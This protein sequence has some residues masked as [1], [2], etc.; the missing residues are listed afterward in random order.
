[1][2]AIVN[3][4]PAGPCLDSYWRIQTP[5]L[6]LRFSFSVLHSTPRRCICICMHSCLLSLH[7]D[8]VYCTIPATIS[9]SSSTTG[10]SFAAASLWCGRRRVGRQASFSSF[11]RQSTY[12]STDRRAA[13]MLLLLKRGPSYDDPTA[14]SF[15]L[16]HLHR[17]VFSVIN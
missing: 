16:H 11:H 14:F 1:M 2:F 3:K 13:K 7:D 9:P 12:L 5:F 17:V 4:S 8:G 15:I 6:H 10:R